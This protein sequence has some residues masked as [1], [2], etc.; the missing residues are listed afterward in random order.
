MVYTIATSAQKGSKEIL[1]LLAYLLNFLG[2]KGAFK[3]KKVLYI[4]VSSPPVLSPVEDNNTS[5]SVP[6]TFCEEKRRITRE[7]RKECVVIFEDIFGDVPVMEADLVII[8]FFALEGWSLAE[9]FNVRCVPPGAVPL[10]LSNENLVK[11]FHFCTTF[12]KKLQ[13]IRFVGKTLCIGCGLFLP[14]TEEHRELLSY[15]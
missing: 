2:R 3:Q 7:H 10:L 15:G 9:L 13:V 11:S 4:P 8:N 12:F 5:G 1:I 6:F 14:R